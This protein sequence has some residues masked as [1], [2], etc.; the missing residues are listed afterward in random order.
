MMREV[1]SVEVVVAYDVGWRERNW[2]VFAWDFVER[3]DPYLWNQITLNSTL[4]FARQVQ[5]SGVR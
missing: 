2:E 3:A 5:C 4:L 1:E